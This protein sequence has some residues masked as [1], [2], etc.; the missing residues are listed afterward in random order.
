MT[1]NN[2]E[3]KVL[4][5]KSVN[6]ALNYAID[7]NMKEDPAGIENSLMNGQ[8]YMSKEIGVIFLVDENK[9]L[10]NWHINN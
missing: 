6:D 7:I 4:T 1:K 2:K 5:F 8:R 3:P 9:I 10:G